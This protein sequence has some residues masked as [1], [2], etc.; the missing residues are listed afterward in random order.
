MG[1][2]RETASQRT[3]SLRAIGTFPRVDTGGCMW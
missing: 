3:V 1:V 2:Q